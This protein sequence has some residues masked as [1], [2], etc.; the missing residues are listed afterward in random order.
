MTLPLLPRRA[1]LQ[2]LAAAGVG[3]GAALAPLLHARPA[4]QRLAWD[5]F[6]HGLGKW[7]IEAEQPAR[8]SARDGVLDIE[9]P[10]GLTL[11]FRQRFEG[12]LVITYDALAVSEGGANDRVS[13]LNCFWMARDPAVASGDALARARSGKFE[14]YDDLAT[15]YVGLGGNGN[16]TTRL[17]R[18]VG[19]PG[20]RPLLPENDRCDA[21]DMLVANRWQRL[22]LVADAGRIGF[23]RDNRQLFALHDTAPYTSGYF[24]LRTTASHLRI[25]DFA[26]TRLAR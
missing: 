23:F 7:R 18:Y 25:R 24:A 19:R 21:A 8:V 13:D 14:D 4:G 9:A 2:G 1:V 3:A 22:R 11:W 15:Y 10:A 20:I 26:V 6:R 17:R 12:P 16:T 5:D